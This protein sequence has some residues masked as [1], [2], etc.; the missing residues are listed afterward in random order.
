MSDLWLCPHAHSVASPD[1]GRCEMIEMV[2]DQ[3]VSAGNDALILDEVTQ[4]NWEEWVNK[5]TIYDRKNKLKLTYYSGFGDIYIMDI[6]NAGKRGKT[7]LQ[8]SIKLEKPDRHYCTHNFFRASLVETF[9]ELRSLDMSGVDRF[10][11]KE[12]E[13]DGRKWHISHFEERSARIFSPFNLLEIYKPL[14]EEPKKWTVPHALR[15]IINGQY[16]YLKCNGVYTDDYAYDAAVNFKK[17]EITGN[18]IFA[19]RIL[20]SPSGWHCWKDSEDGSINI[21]CHSF[22]SNEFKLRI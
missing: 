9:K 6:S 4:E 5:H 3:E 20:T 17:G 22:D 16:E 2:K 15:A 12:I 11:S 1:K 14:K 13:R 19:V 8:I 7:C 10:S 18:I 21:S